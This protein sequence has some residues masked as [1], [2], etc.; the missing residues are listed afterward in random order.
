MS[1][2]MLVDTWSSIYSNLIDLGVKLDAADA[3]G[4][5]YVLIEGREFSVEN[6]FHKYDHMYANLLRL[7]KEAIERGITLLPL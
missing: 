1:K 6:A 4:E 5:D 2:E 3:A 7:E